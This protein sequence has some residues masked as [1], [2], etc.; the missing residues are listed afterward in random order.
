MIGRGVLHPDD[1]QRA[2]DAMAR[3][4]DEMTAVPGIRPSDDF[5][6]R[7]MAAIES[8]PVPDRKSVV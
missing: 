4:L 5:V 2:A 6:D 3:E 7:V 1:E 8:E